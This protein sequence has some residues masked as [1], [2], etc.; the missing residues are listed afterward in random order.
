[1]KSK[2]QLQAVNDF[3][4]TKEILRLVIKKLYSQALL[5]SLA[6]IVILVVTYTTTTLRNQAGLIIL[7]ILFVFLG[8]IV[9]YF[10]E[11]K[12]KV[13]SGDPKVQS[14]LLGEQLKAIKNQSGDFTVQVWTN[15]ADNRIPGSRDINILPSQKD[16]AYHIGDR[17]KVLFRANRDCYLTLLNLGTSGK[18]TILFPNAL[19][20]D[21]SIS[22]NR[23]YEIPT[24]EYGFDYELQGPVGVEKLKVI[25]TLEKIDL[26]ESQFAMNGS[27]FLTKSQTAASRDIAVIK[28]NV[29]AIQLD[30]WVE[31]T[32]EFRVEQ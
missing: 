28:K 32:C 15:F 27:L 31:R 22:A 7:A 12:N 8:G 5:F 18:L 26:V 11:M 14:Q 25:A 29:K 3:F 20:R 6:I 21:N 23:V 2:K 4:G 19:Y 24:K 16:T 1:M 10:F 13:E 30:K 17:I 9:A